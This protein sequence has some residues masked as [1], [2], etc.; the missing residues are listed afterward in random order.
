MVNPMKGL[1]GRKLGPGVV[2]LVVV[3]G[4]LAGFLHL[5]TW[6]VDSR[7]VT[8][9]GGPKSELALLPSGER[10]MMPELRGIEAWIN[11]EP[12]TVAGQ[13]GKVVLVDFWT[14]ACINCIRTTPHLRELHDK[15]SEHGLV[16]IGVHTPEFAF[17]ANVDNVR[18]A[19]VELGVV[20]PVA[21]DNGYETWNAYK[22]RFWPHLFIADA[23]GRMRYDHIGE[24]AY[25]ETERVIRELLMEAGWDVSGVSTEV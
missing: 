12:L 2:S 1:K 23:E 20:W 3:V 13:R 7:G 10:P 4:I 16:M 19:S 24:G 8:A 5:W 25:I 18:E 9:R 15:Y 22:N 14:F 6:Y 11:S 17:E 21:I